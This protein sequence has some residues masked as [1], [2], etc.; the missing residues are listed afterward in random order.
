MTVNLGYA[1]INTELRAQGV[2]S[3]RTCRI[4]T[5]IKTPEALYSLID[6]NLLDLLTIL[7]WNA[8]H[9]VKLFRISSQLFPLMS[10]KDWGYNL[11]SY[12]DTLKTIGNYAKANG[13]R[14]S[15]HVGQWTL[16]SSVNEQ[17]TLNSIKDLEMHCEILDAMGCDHNS[18]IVIHGGRK[19]GIQD[20]RKN[21]MRLPDNVKKRIALENC[22]IAYK[23]ED[24]L[25]V[26]E[27]FGIPLILDYHHY[28]LNKD[29]PL[30]ELMPRILDTWY[31]RDLRPKF[32]MSE[33]C[34]HANPK[35]MTSMRKHSDIIYN[36]PDNLP[37]NI[38]LM[39]EAKLKEQ[40]VFYLR[41]K[42]ADRLKITEI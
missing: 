17:T 41:E 3:S 30:E 33:G 27:E 31:K 8:K 38:D 18:V 24:L 23:V 12:H 13:I 36:L 7:E 14:L 40:S 6:K 39:L 32:H 19:N 16:L 2:F 10:H 42:Y 28:N 21:F 34:E 29:Q 35:S 4:S 1:C 25:P 26:C 37:D 9:Q 11:V 20:L 5:L 22:E 15:M